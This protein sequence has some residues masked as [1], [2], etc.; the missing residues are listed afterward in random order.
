MISGLLIVSALGAIFSPRIIY[1]VVCAFIAFVTV[2]FVY[3]MLNAPFNAAVQI[4]IYGIAVSILFIF[5]IMLTGYYKEKNLYIA[6]APRTLFAAGGIFL[7]FISSVVFGFEDIRNELD[8]SLVSSKISSLF[9]TTYPIARG[10]FTNYVFAFEILSIFLLVAVI[11][12]AVIL[13]FKRGE[14]K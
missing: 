14:D 8:C 2:S 10:I 9:D 5:S 1:S 12:F 4:A 7:I 11:G 3:F 6:I 13:T